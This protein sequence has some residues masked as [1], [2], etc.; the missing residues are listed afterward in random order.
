M[1]LATA[2]LGGSKA[3]TPATSA[4]QFSYRRKLDCPC[5][6]PDAPAQIPTNNQEFVTNGPAFAVHSGVNLHSEP[7]SCLSAT[8][9]PP[10]VSGEQSQIGRYQ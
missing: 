2:A 9:S 4:A 1:F 8:L 6:E 3:S 7:A 10:G 5:E